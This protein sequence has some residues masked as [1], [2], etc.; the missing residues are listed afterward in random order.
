MQGSGRRIAV[1]G[2]GVVAPCGVG[3]E[4]FWNGLLGPGLV[5]VGR[6]TI[7]RRLGSIA[8]VRLS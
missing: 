1:T 3:K 7:H 5:D 8:M 2:L 4:A 6:R